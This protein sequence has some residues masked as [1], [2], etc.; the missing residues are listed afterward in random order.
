MQIRRSYRSGDVLQ[1]KDE[2]DQE[3]RF[4]GIALV[5]CI[6][7]SWEMSTEAFVRSLLSIDPQLRKSACEAIDEP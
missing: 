6:P 3:K 2:R 4:I 7:C 5:V 1:H